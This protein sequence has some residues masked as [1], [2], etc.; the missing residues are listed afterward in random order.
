MAG[1]CFTIGVFQD[2]AWAAKGL[3]A[4]A[5]HGF[6]PESLTVLAK[7]TPEARGLIKTHLQQEPQTIDVVG[8]GPVAAHGPLVAELQGADNRLSASGLAAT[9]GRAGFQT[10]DGQIYERLTARGG[11]LVA[12]HH[13]PRAADALATLHAYGGGN[14]AIGAYAGRV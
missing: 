13:E 4:L 8:L 10:H 2:A 1:R 12:I 9:I 14:A 7:D 11:I 5:K 3:D 6:V